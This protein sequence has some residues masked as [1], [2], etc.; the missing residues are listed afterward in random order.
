MLVLKWWFQAKSLNHNPNL[1]YIEAFQLSRLHKDASAFYVFSF[2]ASLWKKCYFASI[3]AWHLIHILSVY[4]HQ[5]FSTSAPGSLEGKLL[6]SSRALYD[7]TNPVECTR[8]TTFFF[9]GKYMYV[10]I[11]NGIMHVML[12]QLS[13]CGK[14]RLMQNAKVNSKHPVIILKTICFGYSN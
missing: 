1:A 9:L 3:T 10:E 14:W 4:S 13:E 8:N 6:Q 11:C 5:H 7:I 12:F 2:R